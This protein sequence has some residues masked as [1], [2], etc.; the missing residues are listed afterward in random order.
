MIKGYFGYLFVLFLL[1]STTIATKS[2][3]GQ[4]EINWIDIFEN[5]DSLTDWEITHGNWTVVNGTLMVTEVVPIP[6]LNIPYGSIWREQTQMMGT[7]SFDILPTGT[8]TF[9]FL[10]YFIGNGLGGSV[11][12]HP[13][14]GYAL[15]LWND[16]RVALDYVA[17]GGYQYTIKEYQPSSSFVG[18][19]HFDIT[20]DNNTGE[21]VVFINDTEI[22]RTTHQEVSFSENISISAELG[23]KFD[24]IEFNSTIKPT[25]ID[26]TTPPSD[27]TSSPVSSTDTSSTPNRSSFLHFFTT[28]MFLTVT[29]IHRKRIS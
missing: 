12:N 24:N 7:L 23:V 11:N 22:L 29:I 25:T 6:P 16:H 10:V 3:T 20:N 5:P 27:T 2:H 19:I 4:T 15:H 18:W 14:E 28:I 21:K 13:H 26:T 17:N 8:E 1:I 9:G